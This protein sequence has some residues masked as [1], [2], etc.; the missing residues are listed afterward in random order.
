MFRLTVKNLAANR[1]RFALTTFAVVLAVSFVVSAFVLTDGLRSSFGTLSEDIVAG[2]DLEV[3]PAGDFGTDDRLDPSLVSEAAAVD[4]VA[5]AAGAFLAT[6]N[7]VRPVNADGD[8]IP[9]TGPPQLAFGWIDSEALSQFRLVEGSAPGSG[10]FTMD[11]DSAANHGFSVGERYQVVTPTGVKELTLAGLTSFGENNDTLGAT[12]MQFDLATL[13]DAVGETGYSSIRIALETGADRG[14]V[15]ADL[16]GLAPTTEVVDNATL[17]SEQE[18][19]FNEGIDIIGNVLLGFAGVSLFVSTFIIYNTFAIVLGQRTRELA[20]MRTVGADPAQLRR[21]VMG[22]AAFIGVIASVLGMGAG[23]GV[24]YGLRSL[25]NAIGATL[26]DS[27]LVLSPRT[28]IAAA[29]VGIGVTLASAIFP[30]RKASTVP[31]IAALRDGAAAGQRSG[32]SRLVAGFAIAA[33]GAAALAVGLF[34]ADTTLSVVALLAVGA[35][36]VFVGITLISPIT[37]RPITA[38]LGWPAARVFGVSGH[39][40]RQNAGRNPQRTATTAAA[41]MIGLAMVSMALVVGESVKAQL[42]STL[43]SAVKAEYLVT[44]PNA[45][46]AFPTEM[47]DRIEALPE[48]AAVTTFRYDRAMVAGEER[49]IQGTDYADT[50]VLFDIGVVEGELPTGGVA[51]AGDVVLVSDEEAESAGYE[52]G[53]AIAFTFA[54]G[55][56][57]ALTV[58]GVYTDDIVIEDPFLID[59]STWDAVDAVGTD[60]WMAFSVADGVDEAAVRDALRPDHGRLPSRRARHLRR[61]RRA[62]RGIRRRGA[63]RG[64]RDGRPGR[65]HRPDRYRQHAGPVGVRADPGTGPAAGRRHD[66]APAPPYGPVRGWPGRPVRRHARRRHRHRVRLGCRAGPARVGHV[67]PGGAVRSHRCA[68]GG[69]RPGRPA[70]SL[71]PGPASRQARR[72]RR[73]RLVASSQQPTRPHGTTGRPA[74]APDRVGVQR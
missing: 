39:L 56:V 34:V 41:L 31:A 48:T 53:D 23:V 55:E 28:V 54:S 30:A 18:D 33:L 22:E 64:E 4:G 73:H 1:I 35:I 61:L 65:D 10:E 45:F 38:V 15:Q 66:P 27:P 43:D 29:V 9:A 6:D 8:E 5:E 36:A 3:R 47:T 20:L 69:G 42:R 49:W 62:G 68:G 14:Q 74:G 13:Q 21:S 51:G 59:F 72:A 12:L 2:T 57:R 25:F 52:I 60:T 11:L 37:A 7:T 19:D 50:A 32:R 26:P 44:E 16:A 17:Q 71:G 58:V 70:G 40:A 67:D 24:S 63:D 46:T